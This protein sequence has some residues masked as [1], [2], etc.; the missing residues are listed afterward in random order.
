MA[1]CCKLWPMGT[2]TGPTTQYC[3]AP[4]HIRAHVLLFSLSLYIVIG[5]ALASFQTLFTERP[6]DPQPLT[7]PECRERCRRQ[8][9]RTV[10]KRGAT[11]LS[12]RRQDEDC[13]PNP[14]E[15][16]RVECRGPDIEAWLGRSRADVPQTIAHDSHRMHIL[17]RAPGPDQGAAGHMYTPTRAQ[18]R[19]S[20]CPAS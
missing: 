14:M 10:S 8:G 7:M 18:C 2:R 5:C 6:D 16:P 15:H 13:R 9:D 4:L 3:H 1:R 11:G 12:W 17:Q 19:A 20:Q